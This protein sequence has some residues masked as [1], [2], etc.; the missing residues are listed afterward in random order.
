[1]VAVTSRV[2]VVAVLP[3]GGPADPAVETTDGETWALGVTACDLGLDQRTHLG[4]L[5]Q[6]GSG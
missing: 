3:L 5:D 4:V 1:M 6:R 2:V